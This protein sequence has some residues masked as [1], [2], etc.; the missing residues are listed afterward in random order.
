MQLALGSNANASKA[1]LNLRK[2]QAAVLRQIHV[3]E[4]EEIE[5][6][7]EMSRTQV[8]ALDAAS[9][10]DQQKEHLVSAMKELKDKEILVE[11]YQVEIRQRNDEIDKKMYLVDRLN[12]KYEKIVEMAGGEESLGPLE[13]T[14]RNIVKEMGSIEEEC[15]ELERE[16]LK[17]Q[18]E[19]VAVVSESEK[20]SE[21]NAEQQ[22]RVTVLS[23]QVDCIL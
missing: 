6:L 14:I 1:M 11:K 20:V 2:N 17:R 12:K 5:T 3:K 21:E 18:T 15:K 10:R 4:N 16:W 23:Q 22:A 13:S 9:M 7:N 19:M 8:E